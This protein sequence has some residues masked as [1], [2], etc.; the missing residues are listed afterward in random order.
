MVLSHMLWILVALP[1]R[2]HR[3]PQAVVRLSAKIPSHFLKV[4]RP[5]RRSAT[6]AERVLIPLAPLRFALGDRTTSIQVASK[7]STTFHKKP[8]I[9]KDLTAL[10]DF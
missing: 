10:L 2:E 8:T 4:L 9:S 6:G 1:P 7:F 5:A 3:V